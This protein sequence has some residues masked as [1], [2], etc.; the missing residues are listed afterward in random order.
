MVLVVRYVALVL[1]AGLAAGCGAPTVTAAPT[2]EQRLATDLLTPRDLP[3]GFVVDMRGGSGNAPTVCGLPADPVTVPHAEVQ[4]SQGGVRTSV[5]DVLM[6]EP[7]GRA[8]ELLDGVAAGLGSCHRFTRQVRNGQLV[9]SVWA[10]P[11]PTLA[12]QTVALRMLAT[13][14]T[15]RYTYD[16]VA[17]RRGDTLAVIGNG[18]LYLDSALTVSL[19]RAQAARTPGRL[20]A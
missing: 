17:L 15:S 16:L 10:V 3:P 11:F 12:D 13:V 6:E 7:P 4:F 14:G 9:F 5:F 18:G 20:P 8:K 2:A 1:V 19:A